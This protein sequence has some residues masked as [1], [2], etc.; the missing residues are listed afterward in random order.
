VKENF[1]GKL[2]SVSKKVNYEIK[3]R[4]KQTINCH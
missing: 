4:M 3:H 2:L 1:E